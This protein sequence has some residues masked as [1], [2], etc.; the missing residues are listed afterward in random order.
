M[1]RI[2]EDKTL[3]LSPKRLALKRDTRGLSTVE[4]VILLALIAVVAISA[5]RA[6]GTSVVTKVNNGATQVNGI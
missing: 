4:Y 2:E 5:W 1:E 6:F 3:S